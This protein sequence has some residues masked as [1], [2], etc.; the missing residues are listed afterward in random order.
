VI[1]QRTH[2]GFAT[3]AAEDV[4]VFFGAVELP[5]EAQQLEQKRSALGVGRV[6]P[7]LGANASIASSSRPA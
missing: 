1:Q 2:L 5:R 7:D 3:A 4:E 6:V